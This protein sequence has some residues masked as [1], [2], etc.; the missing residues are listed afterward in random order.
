MKC[1]H[2]QTENPPLAKFC[3]ECATPLA[4]T[5]ANCRTKLPPAAKFCPECA[6]PMSARAATQARFAS[7]D[8]YTPKHL[9]EKILTSRSGRGL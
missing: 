5:C 7:P 3:L 6:H 9:A 8:A 2:C 1:P 4:H